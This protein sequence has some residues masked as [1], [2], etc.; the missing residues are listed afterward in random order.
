MFNPFWKG[1][2]EVIDFTDNN[3]LRIRKKEKILRVYIDQT[4]PYF[5]DDGQNIDSPGTSVNS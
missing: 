4:M 3:N 1:S 5:T 2:Y